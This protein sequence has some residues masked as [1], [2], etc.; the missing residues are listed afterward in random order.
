[1]LNSTLCYHSNTK[2]LLTGTIAAAIAG[3]KTIKSF[4]QN[5]AQFTDCI[6]EIN[7]TQVDN[8]SNLD[9]VMSI[10]NVI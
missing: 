8:I 10:N 4:I 3:D 5:S 6:R 7:N 9:V 1:M 2:I